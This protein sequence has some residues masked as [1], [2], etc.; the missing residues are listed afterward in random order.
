MSWVLYWALAWAMLML[1]LTIRNAVAE[2]DQEIS[3]RRRR[4]VG[5]NELPDYPMPEAWKPKRLPRS[6]AQIPEVDV[7]LGDFSISP[8][9]KPSDHF[10][11]E[12][13]TDD[14]IG[15]IEIGLYNDMV[16]Y[17]SDWTKHPEFLAQN[18]KV[19][20]RLAGLEENE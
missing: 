15:D 12:P 3:R 13:F 9:T 1:F 7:M 20:N 6:V 5:E 2:A 8:R 11:I 4:G 14:F 16:V 10:V 17:A 19:V 18:P